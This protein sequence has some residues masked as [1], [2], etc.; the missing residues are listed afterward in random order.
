MLCG[1]KTNNAQQSISDPHELVDTRDYLSPKGW[2]LAIVMEVRAHSASDDREVGC[3][4]RQRGIYP[5]QAAQGP[6]KYET[7]PYHIRWIA[8]KGSTSKPWPLEMI[9]AG[10]IPT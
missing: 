5:E 8:S 7:Q 10:F 4:V 6:P 3:K 1:R 9:L 2:V